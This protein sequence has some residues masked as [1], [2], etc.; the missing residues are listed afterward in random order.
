MEHSAEAAAQER[1]DKRRTLISLL[2]AFA[3][4]IVG[5]FAFLRFYNVYIDNILYAERLNQMREVTTQLYSGLEDVVQNQWRLVDQQTRTLKWSKPQSWSSFQAFMKEQ[6]Y[7]AD[8]DSIQCDIMAVDTNGAY[9]TQDGRQ[10]LLQEREYLMNEPEQLSYVSSALVSDETRMVFLRRLD[11]PITILSDDGPITLKY[12]GISERMEQLNPYFECAAYSGKSSVYVVDNNGL[13]LFSSSSSSGDLLKGYNVYTVLENM[14]YLHGAKFAD[15]VQALEDDHIAYSNALLGDTEIYYSL[16]RMN[17]SEW[18]LVFLVPSEYV[19]V[20][21]VDLVN[22]TVHLVL[23]FSIIL[24]AVSIALIF[25]L[26]K[27]QQKTALDVERRN[28]EK[29][30]KLNAELE[31]ASQ[32]K[33]D[34]L[35]NMSHDI[36]TPMNAIV[37]ITR[38]MAHDK[39]DPIKMETYIH[40]VQMSSQHLLSLINDVLDMSKIESNNIKLNIEPVELAEQVAQIESIVRPQTEEHKQHFVLRV[41]EICHE[42]LLGDAVRL[43]QIII[44]LLS[45]AVKYTQNG[46]EIV[47]EVAELPC[48]EADHAKFRISVTDNGYGMSPEFVKHIFEPFTRAENSTTNRVQGTG[49]GMAITKNI[50]DL[51]GG[52]ITVQSEPGNGSRFEVT[53][54][55]AIN[56]SA[57]TAL[58]FHKALLITDDAGFITNLK[59]AF[60]ETD[61]ALSVAQ[62]EG[63]AEAILRREPMDIVLLGSTLQ[64]SVLADN[65]ARLRSEAGKALLFYC[66][67]YEGQDQL[68][69]IARN[70]GVDAVLTRPFFV[71]NLINAYDRATNEAPAVEENDSQILHGMRFLCA[72]DN[73]LNAE[74]L[75][76]ILDMNHATCKIYENGQEIVDAFATV[77]P[78]EYDAI[79]M[80]V[81][82][83]VMNGL[84]ATRAI[85]RSENPLGKTIPIIAMTANAFSEDVQHC[86]D[87]GMDAHVSK[88]LDIA[89]LERTLRTL[90]TPPPEKLL[91]ER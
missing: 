82:M 32:A 13:K 89:T 22:T 57:H 72:E 19:A 43:R 31:V 2:I 46:G 15:A 85:R 41:Q 69:A 33:T 8:M 87:A 38:L 10:G 7:L 28:N 16:Y 88:P 49:L 51:M 26:L 80:D 5:V 40:K 91:T 83:P 75:S 63:E 76:A 66:C 86:L 12:Y 50:I 67:E 52:T 59:A 3:L 4:I 23:V 34:F 54:S 53:V 60:S 61:V 27:K 20:N 81:Q 64:G 78:G 25:W 47:F 84:D 58:P 6:V 9:Y 79:L 35:A 68:D 36:R 17:N 56:Q 39:D 70:G 24:I 42:H 55:F 18:T 37:G 90:V 62:F 21:T 71:S 65:V 77:K 44:N 1:K 11:S 73:A 30:E 74:I 48:D 29:L 45:N 14:S